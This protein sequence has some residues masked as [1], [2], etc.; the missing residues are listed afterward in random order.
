MVNQFRFG[1]EKEK[2]VARSLR[3]IGASVNLSKASKGPADIQVTFPTRTKWLIQVKATR[4]GEPAA[5]PAKDIERLKK[6]ALRAGAT[7]VIADVIPKG[8][9][10]TSIRSGRRLL[11]PKKKHSR[12]KKKK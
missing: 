9:E 1:R 5:P 11:P 7:P 4:S 3:A 6:A 2:K 10:Y 8:I 12:A